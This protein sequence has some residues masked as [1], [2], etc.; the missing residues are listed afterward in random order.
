MVATGRFDLF[1]RGA[2]ELL[3]EFGSHKKI[4][5]LMYDKSI[6]LYYPLPRFFFTAKSNTRAIKRI[7]EGLIAAYQ[8]GS[9]EKVW[10]KQYGPSVSYSNSAVV[11]AKKV[12]KTKKLKKD[13]LFAGQTERIM[14]C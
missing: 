2:N 12:K 6:A 14:L 9:I 10:K 11:S 8:D 13:E 3:K 4:K 7:E 5:D 1:A